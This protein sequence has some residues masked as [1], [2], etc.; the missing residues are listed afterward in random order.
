M[1]RTLLLINGSPRSNGITAQMLRAIEKD[2]TT[3][4]AGW[5]TIFLDISRMN[6][7]PCTGCMK[8]R[9]SKKCQLTA[10]DAHA[11]AMYIDKADAIVIGTPAYWADMT[12]TLKVLFDRL[13]YVLMDEPA[14]K[15]GRPG[16]RLHGKK[17]GIVTCCNA[18]S[19][20]DFATGMSRRPVK[21]IRN[22][23]RWSGI[24]FAGAVRK[25]DAYHDHTLPIKKLS[26][27]A[28]RLTKV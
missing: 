18:G 4:V 27:L 3:A 28:R 13:V 22:V 21:S 26:R 8:C 6:V 14:G 9:T 12:G 7:R 23:F 15:L 24:K 11:A 1:T 2:V 25:H 19:L 20:A 16:P 5:E 17:L 10:D